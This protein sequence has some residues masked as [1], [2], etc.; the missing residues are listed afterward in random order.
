[1]PI[2][3]PSTI[4]TL[5]TD[6]LM[7]AGIIGI[8]EVA[9]DPILNRTLRAYNRMLS[10]WNTDRFMIFHLKDYSVTSTGAES[11]TVGVGQ[12]LNTPGNPPDR[13]ESAFLRQIA[14]TGTNSSMPFD[15]PLSIIPA[16]ETYNL[17]RLKTLGTFAKSIFYDTSF[18][19]AYVRPWPLP[20]ASIY[21]IHVTFKEQLLQNS[22]IND[23][24]LFPPF[25]EACIEYCLARR[26]RSNYQMSADAELNAMARGAKA[27]VVRANVQ[28]PRAVL[29]R[30]ILNIGGSTYNYRSDTY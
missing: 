7:D 15:W 27:A 1:M 28:I 10:Q 8:D 23:Q 29:P 24:I 4:K 16:R 17:I 13:I 2:P 9:E 30:E 21:E 20:Q 6:A 26:L 3:A 12:Q 19:I 25:Y 11:Y 5:L 14:G 18:P 22:N